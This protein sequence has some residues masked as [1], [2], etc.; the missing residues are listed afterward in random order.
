MP[1]PQLSGLIAA[2]AVDAI[3]AQ[4]ILN[5]RHEAELAVFG[6]LAAAAPIPDLLRPLLPARQQLDQFQLS[7]SAGIAVTQEA[8][9]TVR[10]LLLN[11]EILFS[12]S[13]KIEQHSRITV[14]VHQ[15][16]VLQPFPS[17]EEQSPWPN[18]QAI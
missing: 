1:V 7:F 11:S 14:T 9:L 17:P 2:T 5:H 10:V 18:T 3:N 6:A 12:T 13:T 16:P 4:L 15:V 8:E